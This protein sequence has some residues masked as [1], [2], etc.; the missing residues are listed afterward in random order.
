MEAYITV[1]EKASSKL[2]SNEAE[3]LRS[4]VSHLP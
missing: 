3:E 4:D 1:V 2:S